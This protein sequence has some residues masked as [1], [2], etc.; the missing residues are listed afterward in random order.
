MNV[1]CDID[2]TL[3]DQPLKMWGNPNMEAIGKLKELARSGKHRVHLWS[4][5]GYKYAKAFAEKYG[6]IQEGIIPLGKPDVLI[7]DNPKLR[8]KKRIRYIPPEQFMKE[9]L[10]DGI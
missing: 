3:T 5:G 1:F 2:G 7:D 9:G 6:L 10:T 4:G 8:P